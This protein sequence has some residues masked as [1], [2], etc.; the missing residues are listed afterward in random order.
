MYMGNLESEKSR[1]SNIHFILL[2]YLNFRRI[3]YNFE[4]KHTIKE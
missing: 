4:G 3:R 2:Y 1:S